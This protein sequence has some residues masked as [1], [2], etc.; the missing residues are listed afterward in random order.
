V[1]D[2]PAPSV[3]GVL[4]AGLSALSVDVSDLDDVSDLSEVEVELEDF[5]ASMAF[6]RDSEG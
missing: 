2:E 1:P 6:L 5:S 3:F 4:A